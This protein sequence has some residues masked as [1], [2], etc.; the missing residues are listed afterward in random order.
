[1]NR[2]RTSAIV[3]P[4]RRTLLSV[5]FVVAFAAVAAGQAT[6]SVVVEHVSFGE[7]PVEIIG[8]E[9]AGVPYKLSESQPRKF[10]ASFDAPEDWL[11]RLA[12][13]VKNKTDKTILTI[14]LN[15]S[16]A[17]GAEGEVPMGFDVRYGQELDESAFTGRAP[18]GEPR[19]LPPGET[20]NAQWTETEYSELIKFLALKHPVANYRKMR[21]DPYEV[22]FDDG[23]VWT[24]SGIYRIDPRDPR[25]WS[26]LDGKANEKPQSPPLNAGEKV[27][28]VRALPSRSGDDILEVVD[29]KVAGQSVTPGRPFMADEEWLRNLSVRIKNTSSKPIASIRL[30]LSLPEAKYRAGGLGISLNYG[31]RTKAEKETGDAK[32]LVPGGETELKFTAAEYES[33]RKFVSERSSVSSFSRL[34]FGHASVSFEDGTRGIGWNLIRAPN[35]PEQNGA[36]K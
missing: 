35:A 29:I 7:F 1:M 11:R 16:L 27:I 26:P 34:I 21:V 5:T 6:Q 36:K 13:R 30:Q 33:H 22:H 31:G 2:M 12:F 19:Q 10:V 24:Q 20:A 28:T 8:L 14:K 25:K 32:P 18:R 15:G 4:V 3:P 9:M 17:T 23:T